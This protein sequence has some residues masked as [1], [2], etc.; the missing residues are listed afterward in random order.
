[1]PGWLA[2]LAKL[3]HLPTRGGFAELDVQIDTLRKLR[4]SYQVPSQEHRSDR[5]ADVEQLRI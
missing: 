1:M 3:F 4:D 2:F 5:I